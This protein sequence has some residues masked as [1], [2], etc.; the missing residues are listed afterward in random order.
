MK[1]FPPRIIVAFARTIFWRKYRMILLE[2]LSFTLEAYFGRAAPFS[3]PCSCCFEP[4]RVTSL[5]LSSLRKSFDVFIRQRSPIVGLCFPSSPFT[6]FGRIVAVIINTLKSH[7]IRS[8]RHIIIKINKRMPPFF[9]YR[10]P[11]GSVILVHFMRRVMTSP[12]HLI[13]YRIEGVSR[14]SVG[15]FSHNK[16]P[17]VECIS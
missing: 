13:P 5:F 7:A 17:K 6:V 9:T 4:F 14:H 16:S 8:W 11:S 15:S 2:K 10:Y 12:S 1:L 3:R